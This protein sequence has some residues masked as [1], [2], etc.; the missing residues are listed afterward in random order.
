MSVFSTG[1]GTL[2]R[3]VVS[4]GVNCYKLKHSWPDAFTRIYRYL[5]TGTLLYTANESKI[6]MKLSNEECWF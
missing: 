3:S 1:N 6:L 5:G 2:S 4:E